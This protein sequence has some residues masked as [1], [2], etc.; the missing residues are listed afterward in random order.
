MVGTQI[1]QDGNSTAHQRLCLTSVGIGSVWLT[2]LPGGLCHVL[3][4][5]VIETGLERTYNQ[6]N[7]FFLL[8]RSLKQALE[9]A[10][11]NLPSGETWKSFLS[12]PVRLGGRCAG[13][14][15]VISTA[16][17]FFRDCHVY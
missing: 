6:Q 16:M 10:K 8:L 13:E 17:R 14:R 3:V 5:N 2:V 15:R 7:V 9:M 4:T 12:H 1:P 11:I